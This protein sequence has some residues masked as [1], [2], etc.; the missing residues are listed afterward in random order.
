MNR[1][2]MSMPVDARLYKLDNVQTVRPLPKWGTLSE[3]KR[4]RKD[5]R[6]HLWLCTGLNDTTAA[7]RP[8]AKVI[9]K[10]EHEG[11]IVENIRIESLP[12]LYV[13]GNL[14]RPKDAT[15]PLP[16]VLQPHGHAMRARTVPLD[17]YSVPHRGMNTALQGFAA[18]GWSMIAYDDDAMQIPH[19]AFLSGP[20]KEV[21]NLYGLSTFGLQIH[22]GMKVIDYLSGRREIDAKRI[23][24]TGE[25]GG[26]TQT[27]YLTALD[28]RIK[29]AAPAV[30]LSGHF[31]GGCVCENAPRL[32]LVYG[33][34]HYAGLIAPRPMFL[35]GCTGDWTHH[36][37]ERELVSMR[38][39][40][41]L[42]G[43]EDA[44][45][46]FYQDEMHNYNRASR[47]RVY[48]W[49]MRWLG[50]GSFTGNRIAESK[51]AVPAPERLLVHDSPTPPVKRVIRS[52]KGMIDVWQDLHARADSI[53]D[54]A[55]LLDL[56]LPEKSDLLVKNR[57]PKYASK[58]RDLSANR[59][60]YGRF[61]NDSHL[62]CWF[63]LPEKGE[64]TKLIIGEWNSEKAWADFSVNPSAALKKQIAAGCGV[65]VPLLF[66]QGLSA[67]MSSFRKSV[68]SSSLYSSFNRTTHDQQARD[69]VT[70]VRLAQMEMGV[71]P[72]D[73]DLVAENGVSLLS[74]VVWAALCEQK[75]VGRFIADFDGIDA[76]DPKS[77]TKSAYLPLV[78]RGGGLASLK[79]LCGRRR[80]V[81][82]G[83]TK[84]QAKNL[85]V[86]FTTKRRRHDLGDLLTI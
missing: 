2:D 5:V 37:R 13:M 38:D 18:F 65:I 80:G 85:A 62:S 34:M 82:T 50:D 44:I 57:T 74:Y 22:N 81:V 54:T 31:Q 1:R 73:I 84:D 12:G 23:G 86:G 14:Y 76:E 17:Q 45:D 75:A 47:E 21:C 68:E 48:A 3:W 10:F 63:V 30:M 19:R 42:Y 40:Y 46:G 72:A 32:H 61:S 77:W 66:G 43:R 69:I 58:G 60:T 11:V 52:K 6:R 9:A 4:Q 29:V 83:L 78:L 53:E 56:K 15:K 71:H 49:M 28:E 59:I 41:R 39:L 16:L 67:E 70:T 64:P 25:S 55:T 27:Y 36:M 8:K 26:A 20:E 24:C 79:R 33:T 35:T 7:F 51:L